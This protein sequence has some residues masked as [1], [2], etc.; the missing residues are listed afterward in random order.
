MVQS[1][2]VCSFLSETENSQRR[3]NG[4][5]GW[6]RD[7]TAESQRDVMKCSGIDVLATKLCTQMYI[8][9]GAETTFKCELAR[10]RVD[11]PAPAFVASH[12][13]WQPPV[14]R[15]CSLRPG[16]DPGDKD[17]YI[18]ASRATPARKTSEERL[19]AIEVQCTGHSTLKSPTRR[20]R[21]TSPRGLQ[22]HRRALP[23]RALPWTRRRHSRPRRP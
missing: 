19:P 1:C 21:K 11:D 8:C 14:A 13:L 7:S 22:E 6:G 9:R 18:R 20:H 2:V 17:A 5:D 12:P 10:H 3:G 16:G 15:S 4:D 23:C